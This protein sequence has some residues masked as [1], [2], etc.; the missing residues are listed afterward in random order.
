MASPMLGGIRDV[1]GAE[2]D[3]NTVELARFALDEHNKKSVSLLQIFSIAVH[4]CL[5][6]WFIPFFHYGLFIDP[7][8]IF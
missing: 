8:T 2:N 3:L 6:Y 5:C 4:F 1:S 7:I